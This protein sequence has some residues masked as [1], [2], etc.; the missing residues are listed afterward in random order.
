MHGCAIL[1]VWYLC[2]QSAQVE[3]DIELDQAKLKAALEK[4]TKHNHGEAVSDERKRKYNS[5]TVP[6]PPPTPPQQSHITRQVFI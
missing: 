4:V 2:L 1:S 6:D 3:E 5:F